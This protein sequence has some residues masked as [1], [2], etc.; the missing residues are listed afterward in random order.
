MTN[1]TA[2]LKEEVGTLARREVRRHNASADKTAARCARAIAALKREVQ[3]LGHDLAASLGTRRPG[4]AIAPRK[5]RGRGSPGRRAAKKP[6]ATSA[7][8]EPAARNPFS[9]EALK[10]HRERLG[11][12]AENYG[13]LLG[14]SRLSIYNWEQGKA[15]PRKSSVDAWTALRRIGKREAARRLASLK[16]AKPKSESMQ[17]PAEK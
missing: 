6:G 8:A 5:T 14:A 1:L 12:S 10:A 4:R 2:A 3:A 11:L 16:A 17:K 15:R 13:K 7:A 9:G